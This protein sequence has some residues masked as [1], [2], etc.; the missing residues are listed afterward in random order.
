MVPNHLVELNSSVDLEMIW[1]Q[2]GTFTMGSPTS[3]VG[4]EVDETEH[5]VTVT[6]GF[7]LGKY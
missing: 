1:V 5:N 7:Y 6:K 2:P 3:E 4:R